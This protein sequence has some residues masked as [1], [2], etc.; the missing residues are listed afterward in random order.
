M[1]KKFG[2]PGLIGILIAAGIHWW[3]DFNL[4]EAATFAL[5]FICVGVVELASVGFRALKARAPAEPT[6][7]EGEAP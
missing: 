2:L 4:S 7:A 6:E 3:L 5:Y 1:I